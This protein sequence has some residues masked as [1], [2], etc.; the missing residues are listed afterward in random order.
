MTVV[1]SGWQAGG[2]VTADKTMRQMRENVRRARTHPLVWETARRIVAAVSPRDEQ[3]QAR[4]IRE[5]LDARFRFTRDPLGTELLLTPTY[6]LGRIADQGFVQGDCDDAA[7]M[8]AALGTSLGMPARFMA[9]AFGEDQPYSH[10]FTVLYP[11]TRTGARMPMEM[12]VARPA[13]RPY[14]PSRFKRHLA[15]TV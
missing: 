12:D 5:W 10:V 6:L 15:L 2:K 1:L 8:A 4:T 14:E 3:G 11:R 13:D 7:T 9:V